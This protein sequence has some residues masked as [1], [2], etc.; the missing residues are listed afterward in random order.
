ML[1]RDQPDGVDPTDYGKIV[2]IHSSGHPDDGTL[3]NIAFLIDALRPSNQ[4]KP[5]ADKRRR[6]LFAVA[7]QI[8]NSRFHRSR[9]H[10]PLLIDRLVR[11]HQQIVMA[12]FIKT[13]DVCA[14]LARTP[15]DNSGEAGHAP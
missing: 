1:D 5:A 10:D 9:R 8:A 14:R 3:R 11:H 2:G 7:A 6:P 15:L 12:L 13:F 4:P